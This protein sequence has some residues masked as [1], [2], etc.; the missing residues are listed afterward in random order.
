MGFN[1]ITALSLTDLF[2]QQIENM[3]LSG[4]LAVGEQL[5]PAREL[6]IKMG[7]SRPVISAGLVELEKLGFVEVRPR[8]GVYVC[9]YRRK[10][11]METLVAI[12][13]YN[14][15]ALRQNE[16]RS[17]LETREAMESLCV[18]LVCERVSTGE[19]EQLSPI[20]DGIR[21]AKDPE[22]A[23]E[24]TFVF[25]HE[26]AV[27]SGNVLMP[28]L[29]HSFHPQG[30]YLWSMYCK[31]SG[32]QQLYQIKLRL[33]SALLNRDVDSAMEQTRAIM[34]N[35]IKDLSFYGA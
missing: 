34:Q 15:G 32:I 5:P 6:S 12:M 21:D 29:Y 3:I 23:A 28:L 20:L 27:L 24:Q 18:K 35:A 22:E 19:L 2:V 9:D 30:V 16:V 1:K 33:Y 14:G 31:R 11:T 4:E 7:V 8:Q 13:R 26:L 10:G 25:H 17:L